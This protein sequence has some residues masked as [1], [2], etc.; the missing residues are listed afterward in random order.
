MGF[1]L[2]SIS[3]LFVIFIVSTVYAGERLEF[4]IVQTKTQERVNIYL[5]DKQ[6]RIVTSANPSSALIF[7]ATHRQLHILNHTEKSVTTLDQASLEQLASVAQGLGEIAQSQGGVLGDLF[8]TFG[9]NNSLGN[10]AIIETKTISGQRQFSGKTCQMLQVFKDTQ[11]ATQLCFS[12]ENIVQANEQAT[13][14]TLISFAQLLA[15]KGQIVLEQFGLP[16]PVMPNH[17]LDGLPI[18]IENVADKTSATLAK[19][20]KMDVQPKQ[21]AIPAG[22]ARR[23]FS[24]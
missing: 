12:T 9:L 23:T 13:L 1:L 18:Y 4:D 22:Y 21:F 14:N 16:V 6:A 8:K 7:N 10:T 15:N 2:R 19:V 5:Q 20:I 11:L 3:R 24:F 17:N